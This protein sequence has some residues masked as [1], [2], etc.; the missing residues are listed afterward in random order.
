VSGQFLGPRRATG[1]AWRKLFEDFQFSPIFTYGSPYPFNIV[2]GAQTLQTTAA[3][4]AGVARNTGVGFNYQNVDFRLS[5]EF[6]IKEGVRLEGIAEMF[7]AFNRTNLQFPNNTFG[8]GSTPVATFGRP[9]AAND[10]RQM[11]FGLR[12]TF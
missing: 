8:A 12:L 2:T 3:R 5:R 7:N 10:P 6:P 11:Q 1:R 4:P 9:T